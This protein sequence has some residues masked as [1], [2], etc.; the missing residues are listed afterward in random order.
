MEFIWGRNIFL[1]S[2]FKGRG[3]LEGSNIFIKIPYLSKF[4]PPPPPPTVN[5][6]IIKSCVLQVLSKWMQWGEWT[7]V[8][9]FFFE[10]QHH[11][12]ASVFVCLTPFRPGGA[13]HSLKVFPSLL[14]QI[15]TDWLQA[16]CFHFLVWRHALTKSNFSERSC[17]HS[18]CRKHLTDLSL[19]L[20]RIFRFSFSSS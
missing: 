1:I 16:F 18:F 10:I 4:P 2:L 11:G 19:Y 8:S 3:I 13:I 9:V 20:Y 14:P 15:S 7:K 5:W 12:V 17:D 6:C